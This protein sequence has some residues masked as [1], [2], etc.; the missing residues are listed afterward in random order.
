MAYMSIKLYE[1]QMKYLIGQLHEI[2]GIA[3]VVGNKD[4][5]EVVQST[6]QYFNSEETPK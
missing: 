6:I 2:K 3:R 1:R 5:L 4:I